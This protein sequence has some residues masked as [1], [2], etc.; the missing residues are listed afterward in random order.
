[1]IVLEDLHWSDTA[2]IDLVAV[3]AY[4]SDPGPPLLVIG[5]YR[6]V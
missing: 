6:P 3:L 2:T 4:R 5:T 1:V